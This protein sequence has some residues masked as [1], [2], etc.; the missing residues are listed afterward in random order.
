MTLSA[1]L[2]SNPTWQALTWQPLQPPER[3]WAQMGQR[4]AIA[5]MTGQSGAGQSTISA[6]FRLSAHASGR[7][8]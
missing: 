5:R 7:P 1:G 8:A 2:P 4:P 3:R 6:P